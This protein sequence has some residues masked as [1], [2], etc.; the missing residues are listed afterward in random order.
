MEWYP[1]LT[2]F[3]RQIIQQHRQKLA[4][5]V[6]LM[7]SV[8]RLENELLVQACVARL[9]CQTPN[10]FKRCGECHSCQLN[11]AGNHPDWLTIELPAGKSAIG[12][13]PI[14]E[15]IERLNYY[16][17]IG[18]TRI[19]WIKTAE[20]LTAAA[21][22]AL[23][24]TLE[25]PPENCWF[26]LTCETVSRLP[27]TLISRC[28]QFFLPMPT[29]ASSLAWL[30]QVSDRQQDQQL[31]ALRLAACAPAA[32]LTLLQSPDWQQRERLY[33]AIDASAGSN[34]LALLPELTKGESLI[35]LF[36]LQTLLVDVIKSKQGATQWLTNV[37]NIALI[38]QL[39]ASLPVM[40]YQKL[41]DYWLSCRQELAQTAGLN[42]ELLMLEGCL[43]WEQ[44]QKEQAL[45]Q[46]I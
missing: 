40:S 8:A 39:A 23:L 46:G 45:R 33:A 36:W 44:L 1:W 17:T 12:I 29:E 22:N 21:A 24:K 11:N 25:E 30:A 13:E 4:H 16:P 37:D 32:A 2:P 41:L 3:Y 38:K 9:L 19:V 6:M 15:I 43:L 31:A 7:R 27:A 34:P 20:L 42:Q 28:Q 26:F 14:R 5:P 10:D 18:T 35:K